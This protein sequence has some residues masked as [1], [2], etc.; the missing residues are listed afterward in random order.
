MNEIVQAD[1]FFF[2]TAI[3]VV[4][5]GVGMSIALCYIIFILRDVRAVAK[6]VRKASDELEKDFEDLRVNIK[7]EGVRVKTVFD[8]ALRFIARHI[9]KSRTKRP[10]GKVGH[11]AGK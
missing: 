4:V 11:E 6:K 9:P 2:I 8:L 7:E 5:V 1:I 3:A 10:E